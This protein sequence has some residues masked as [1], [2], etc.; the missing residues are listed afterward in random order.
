MFPRV[1]AA[2]TA[3]LL[4][5]RAAFRRSDGWLWSIA[6]SSDIVP[7]M[8]SPEG[9]MQRYEYKVLPAPIRGEKARGVKTTEDRF[10][11]TLAGLLNAQAR[12]GWEYLRTDTL[13]SEERVGFT[14]RQTVFLNVLI[15]RRLAEVEDNTG[16]RLVLTA[17]PKAADAP[18]IQIGEEGAAPK[19]GPA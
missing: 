11:L 18:R 9:A 3:T 13:P 15:F 5:L 16:P 6:A 10:A 14:R 8:I 12:D 4:H 7:I 1:L 19:L 2:T 17:Q